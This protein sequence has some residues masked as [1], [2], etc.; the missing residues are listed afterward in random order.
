M[1]KTEYETRIS[2]RSSDVCSSDLAQRAQQEPQP[3]GKC[4]VA[5][6]V[7]DHLVRGG[8]A[9]VAQARVE[10]GGVRPRVAAAAGLAVVGQDAVQVRVPRARPGR[11][12]GS[13]QAGV[14]SRQREPAAEEDRGRARKRAAKGEVRARLAEN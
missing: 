3:R 12:G 1:R 11:R 7:R 8:D 5:I 10:V 9:P 13:R 14:W 6:V 4:A 2:D